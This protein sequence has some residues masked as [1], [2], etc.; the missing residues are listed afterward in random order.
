MN[1]QK[2]SREQSDEIVN[3]LISAFGRPFRSPVLGLPSDLGLAYENVTFSSEDGV[4]LEGW[5]I[6]REGSN[7]II[8]A[9]HPQWFSRT[10]L[11]AHLEPWKSIGGPAG[12]DF[13]VNFLA[14][15][16]IL[17]DAGYNV[18]TYDL[19]NFGL[20]NTG[21][22]G[23]G[24]NGIWE[25]RDVIGSLSYVRSRPDTKNMTI[26]LFSRCMGANATFYAIERLPEAFEG[27]RCMVSPQP[28]S[29]RATMIKTL[30]LLGIPDRLDDMEQGL[31]IATSFDFDQM[32]PVKAAGKMTLPTFIYQ[33]HDDLLTSPS[34]VQAIFDNIP[35]PKKHLHWIHNTTRRWDG[36]L[37]FQREPEQMLKWFAEY[38]A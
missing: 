19:R 37:Y 23:L 5:F 33:V 31:K 3:G 8:V 2:V 11:P 12:N 4:Q 28:I 30:E 13:E 17:H 20:S 22:G 29:V 26:G 36:Y 7:K 32:S 16:K 9:N 21:N 25:S 10:G 15:Y 14:D 1:D 6:P 35:T 38:M 27:V 24:S 18:L 34:D